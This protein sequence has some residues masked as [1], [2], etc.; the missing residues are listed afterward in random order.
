MKLK[1]RKGQRTDVSEMLRLIKELA[2]YEKAPDE[3]TATETSMLNDGFGAHSIYE[4]LVAEVDEKIVGVAI[5]FISYSTWKGKMVYLDDIIVTESMRGHGIG[6]RLFEEV[7][8]F[9]KAVDANHFR[10]HV[11]D[12]NTPAIEFYKKYDA[13]LDPTWITCKMTKEQIERF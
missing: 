4:S 9:A 11:L 5:F 1:V 8:K 2:T 13:T 12:W 6:K 3:V 7:G 10:W